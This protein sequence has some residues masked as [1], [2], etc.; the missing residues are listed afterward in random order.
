MWYAPDPTSN[1]M[2]P[3]G[4]ISTGDGGRLFALSCVI[5]ISI[6]KTSGCRCYYY[7][8][9]MFTERRYLLKE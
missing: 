2:S 5:S 1:M 3:F 9:M 8:K 4:S 6:L 7:Y